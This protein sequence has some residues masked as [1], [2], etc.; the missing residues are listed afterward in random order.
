MDSVV[1]ILNFFDNLIYSAFF[2]IESSLDE[3]TLDDYE[4]LKLIDIAIESLTS[5]L[6]IKL[7]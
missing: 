6:S 3:S 5:F 4:S 2:L 7:S 1:T